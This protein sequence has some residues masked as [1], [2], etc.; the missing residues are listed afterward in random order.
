M[1]A[2][3]IDLRKRVLADCDAGLG[4]KAVA[5]KY[6]VSPA[7]V[8]RWK[9]RRRENGELGPRPWNA[10]RKRK[11]DRTSVAAAVRARPDAT[12]RELRDALGVD[13]SLQTIHRVLRE[14]KISFKKKSCMPPNKIAPMSPRSVPTGKPGK[15]GSIPAGSCSS[16]KRGRKQT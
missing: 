7:I 3:S 6:R 12:L 11:L 4:T 14:L 9:Q 8:R 10:G 2:Y 15:S 16:T 13:V 5:A 1:R